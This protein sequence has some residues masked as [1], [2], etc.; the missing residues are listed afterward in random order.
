MCGSHRPQWLRTGTHFYLLIHWDN[1]Q[2]GLS[3]HTTINHPDC[4][5]ALW[6]WESIFCDNSRKIYFPSLFSSHY[7][8]QTTGHGPL[9][10]LH[11]VYYKTTR[12]T[13]HL[14]LIVHLIWRLGEG[15]AFWTSPHLKRSCHR[16]GKTNP[17]ES[18]FSSPTILLLFFF[19]FLTKTRVGWFYIQ[20]LCGKFVTS[21]L[22]GDT[23]ELVLKPHPGAGLM[24]RQ[25]Q[26]LLIVSDP[27]K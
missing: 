12:E 23:M 24:L 19:F 7:A 1:A 15:N 14:N 9:V 13:Q 22:P 5:P 18:H 2:K 4:S 6:T 21:E 26:L 8:S 17:T 10:V 27:Y 11:Q 16:P 20:W 25:K 3:I